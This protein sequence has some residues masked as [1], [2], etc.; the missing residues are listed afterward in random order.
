MT[1]PPLAH[2]YRFGAYTLEPVEQRLLRDGRQ[3]HLSGKAHELL[4]V[5][6]SNAGQL[7][8]RE[9]LL[10]TLWPDSTVED[11]NITVHIGA[12][13]RALDDLAH[14]IETVPR[15]G[16][17]F[18]VPVTTIEAPLDAQRSTPL[19]SVPPPS[20]HRSAR[21]LWPIVLAVGAM[22]IVLAIW[23]SVR[24]PLESFSVVVTPQENLPVAG[25]CNAAFTL[26]DG[27][28]LISGGAA[29]SQYPADRADP[30]I[31]D[32]RFWIQ[33]E[34]LRT[35][36]GLG[37]LSGHGNPPD[38][39]RDAATLTRLSDGRILVA[40][41]YGCVN[42]EWEAC[43]FISRERIP[44]ATAV[45]YDPAANRVT[46]V[47]GGM[48]RPRAG[49]TATL[50]T[51]GTVLFVGGYHGPPGS[52]DWGTAV[53]LFDPSAP[54]GAQ[55]RRLEPISQRLAGEL[56]CDTC[57]GEIRKA[58][59][60]ATLL[61]D[62]S[63]LIAGGWRGSSANGRFDGALRYRP[64]D[65][66][67]T[68]AGPTGRPFVRAA[69]AT[70]TLL[71]DGR[72]LFAGGTRDFS[73]AGTLEHVLATTVLYDPASDTQ[74]VGPALSVARV[75]HSATT[76][77]PHSVVLVGGMRCDF[78]VE[79]TLARGPHDPSRT[80]CTANHTGDI[81]TINGSRSAVSTFTMFSG[82]AYHASTVLSDGRI[83]IPGGL[84]SAGRPTITSET[85]TLT[86][87]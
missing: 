40:G 31:Y 23:V 48:H 16:Y 64:G 61:P 85:I 57:G 67:L 32:Q 51:D 12:L 27:R 2:A 13:R 84:V 45:V 68:L 81:V 26:E 43:R 74:T 63:V 77:S 1:P 69:S 56:S 66:G 36:T 47:A 3:V 37:G 18:T 78:S 29:H 80:V 76:V 35:P 8:T 25:C 72:V 73:L 24:A 60:T 54:E 71:G 17:R 82:H 86:R 52:D 50:L 7:V 39:Y 15:L 79:H 30:W 21:R 33:D 59:H 65:P 34:R 20:T 11:S 19:P 70:A 22:V 4:V 5:L 55:F 49:H 10:A 83:L 58:D 87:R 62:G 9:A 38:L 75:G 44:M 41:G 28:V 14:A 46:P 6:V 53:E 42:H